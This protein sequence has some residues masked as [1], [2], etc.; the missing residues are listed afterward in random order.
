[1][2]DDNRS[3]KIIF[4]SHCILNQNAI[5]DGTADFPGALNELIQL[6]ISN[7]IGIVQLPCPELNCL[8]LD[9]GN[10]HGA[11]SP[12]TVENTRIRN[13]LNADH[14]KIKLAS[15]VD[16]ALY[17]IEE[18]MRY[19]FEIIGIIGVN[20]SPSCGIDTTSDQ[21]KEVIGTGVFMALL[22]NRLTEKNIKIHFMGIKTSTYE[23]SILKVKQLLTQ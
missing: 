4:V 22:Q 8:G 16:Q 23:E 7:D 11:L 15:L 17:Q 5:S 9:R 3:K 21:D 14:N 2:F 19:G 13:S 12:V 18:Y 6:I 20:R 10:I 1:M